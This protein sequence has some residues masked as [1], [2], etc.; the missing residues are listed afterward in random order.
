[1]SSIALLP[2]FMK[3]S[4]PVKES[5]GAY[6]TTTE[7]LFKAKYW[8]SNGNRNADFSLTTTGSQMK[9]HFT[10]YYKDDLVGLIWPQT[11]YLSHIGRRRQDT[12][13]YSGVTWVFD[14][15]V[16]GSLP[17][18]NEPGRQLVLTIKT[19]VQEYYVPLVN[20]SDIDNTYITP[21]PEDPPL[22]PPPDPAPVPAYSGRVTLDFDNL[23]EGIGEEPP[24][25]PM[26]SLT[27]YELLIAVISEEYD[28]T[29]SSRLD[30]PL[31]GTLTITNISVTGGSI[32]RNDL[33]IPAN[34]M[35]IAT[36]YD[37]QH[38][39][40]PERIIDEIYDLGYR[41]FL[42]HYV[43]M[44]RYPDKEPYPA[45]GI[46]ALIVKKTGSVINHPTREWH[47]DLATRAAAKGYDIA[48]GISFETFSP[49]ADQSLC[50]V[51]DDGTL[52]KTGYSPTSYFL[53]PGNSAAMDYLKNVFLGF[54]AIMNGRT[55]VR[56]QIGEPWWWWNTTNRKPCF[57][58]YP[59]K[60]AFN[61][62]SA[63]RGDAGGGG[64]YAPDF[65]SVDDTS[66]DPSKVAFKEYLQERL[67][68]SA[69][70]I[71]TAVKSSY[72][73]A[74]VSLLFFAPTIFS[75]DAGM[76]Q[77]VN[78]PLDYYKKPNFDTFV[79]EAYDQH[80]RIEMTQIIIWAQKIKD[81]LGYADSEIEYL[82]GFTPNAELAAAFGWIITGPYKAELTGRYLGISRL[83]K[84]LFSTTRQALWAHPQV[85]ELD[86]V[87][88]ADSQ[89]FELSGRLKYPEINND[90][91]LKNITISGYSGGTPS[92]PTPDTEFNMHMLGDSF[93]SSSW[94]TAMETEFGNR[95]AFM[96]ID[97]V[98]GT[99]LAQQKIRFDGT[100][101]RYDY[102]LVIMD[103][104]LDDEATAAIAAIDGIVA[105]LTHARWVWVQPSPSSWILGSSERTYNDNQLAIIAAH[106]GGNH[107]VETLPGLQA[108]N[109]GSAGDL[110]DVANGLVPRSLRSDYIH[111]NVLGEAGRSKIIADFIRSKGW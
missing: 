78:Y 18:I 87:I 4:P 46:T 100:P 77:T 34:G 93:A 76:M 110:A 45:G 23:N 97:G 104:G 62:W 9:L 8:H 2:F 10:S 64:Y 75:T 53:S 107:Y 72:S 36:S 83:L 32:T 69:T 88:R 38:N 90:K 48:F 24:T 29:D 61:A 43:G 66:T 47:K 99:S 81:E 91:P 57:Y 103:G 40:S 102:T 22:D 111:E 7:S 82:S 41:G 39:V 13:N 59:N 109:D 95:Y 37:D 14:V 52:G 30:V 11:D 85:R 21:E 106:V 58:D 63:A 26:S 94:F 84:K 33:V 108:L 35:G 80:L 5:G 105:H 71:R 89:F 49:F 1:M 28:Q 44:S 55:P 67:G 12:S 19:N 79:W 3:P 51:E 31:E 6:P 42:N 27:V 65:T 101:T 73:G 98:N 92:D 70:D 54:A 15:L 74:E 25:I 56:L 96:T 86:L 68:L 17:A 60:L 20:F 50:Q 16:E